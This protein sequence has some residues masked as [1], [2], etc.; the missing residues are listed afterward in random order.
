MCCLMAVESFSDYMVSGSVWFA[1]SSHTMIALKIN[2]CHKFSFLDHLQSDNGTL[3][4]IKVTQQWGDGQD[5]WWTFHA[6]YYPQVSVIV[7][8]KNHLRKIYHSFLP[9]TDLHI[10]V[11]QFC[12]WIEVFPQRDHLSV[13]FWKMIRTKGRE[14]IIMLYIENSGFCPDHSWEL[15]GILFL[16]NSW[17]CW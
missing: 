6:P 14:F 10:L 17:F 15:C 9:P 16:K 1:D 8:L 7:D 2:M 3:F 12:H 11:R 13:A 4:I 5:I